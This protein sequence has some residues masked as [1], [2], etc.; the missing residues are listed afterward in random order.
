MCGFPNS[1]KTTRAK[2]LYEYIKNILKK[3][4]FLFN[5]ETLL[6]DKNIGY[7][8][9]RAEKS[10][11]GA[12]KSAIERHCTKNAWVIADS[13]NYIK[14]FR[15]EMF[16]IARSAGTPH[17]VVYCDASKE[18]VL[19]INQ[20]LP[21][22][23]RWDNTLIDELIMRFEYPQSTVRWDKPLF[24]V[25]LDD[26]TPLKEIIEHSQ[27][28]NANIAPHVATTQAKLS[29]TNYLYDLDRITKDVI[30]LYLQ[31]Q[32]TVPIG[33]YI[34]F[35]HSQKKIQHRREVGMPELRRL[36]RQYVDLAKQLTLTNASIANLS[37]AQITDAFLDYLD[38]NLQ[39]S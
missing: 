38:S 19:S 12:L 6:I 14:G 23:Q 33:N 1:G 22:Q 34:S 39:S 25:G 16:C 9:S 27:N 37:E 35:A 5:E 11:R 2:E 32:K 13:L 31:R 4:V 20:K 7:K 17:C 15:Y 26:T 8:D 3:D 24:R 29:D 10:T 36:R 28:I 30:D 18:S 21:Q